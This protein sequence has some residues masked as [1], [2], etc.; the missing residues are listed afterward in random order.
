MVHRSASAIVYRRARTPSYS[1]CLRS[2]GERTALPGSSS[3]RTLSSFRSA[4]RFLAFL[5]DEQNLHDQTASV[6]VRVFDLRARKADRG[7]VLDSSPPTGPGRLRLSSLIVTATGAA[8]WR[9][10][11]REDRIGARD[12][13]G[14]HVVLASGPAGSIRDLVLLGGTTARWRN[15]GVVQ[16]RRLDRLGR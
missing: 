1:G 13:D 9:Q 7:V 6:A 4:G 15:G 8:A 3:Q 5:A 12:I 16:S 11:G 10:T 14:R 2:S